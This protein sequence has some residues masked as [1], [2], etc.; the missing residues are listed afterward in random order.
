MVAVTYIWHDCFVV[1]TDKVMMVFDYWKDPTLSKDTLPRFLQEFNRDKSLY[2]MVSHFHKDHYSKTIFEWSRYYPNIHFIISKDV[3][4]HARHIFTPDSIYS[5]FRPDENK[6]IILREG[7]GYM[8][9]KIYIEAFGS[10]DIGNSYYL[11]TDGRSFFHAGD[12]NAW[13]WK[14]ESTEEEV[15]KSIEDYKSILK[16]IASQHK[17]IDYVMFP[18]DSR[19]GSG[20]FTG[21]EMFVREIIVNHFFPMHFELGTDEMERKKFHIDAS[22]FELYAN[23]S[24]GEYIFL[25]TPYSKFVKF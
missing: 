16:T 21:A 15:A 3:A 25:Q 7:E 14:E 5:G 4:R 2:V 6:V 24:K 11:E 23:R 10:T 18:V 12:L 20:Y 17:E 19:I 13:I 8:D 1:E 22:K 9:S